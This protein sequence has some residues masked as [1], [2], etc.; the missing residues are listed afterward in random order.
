M[1][2]PSEAILSMER[3]AT[4]ATMPTRIQEL[5]R[6]LSSMLPQVDRVFVYLD[7]F[8]SVPEFLTDDPKISVF[9]AEELGNYHA[10]S[11]FL[12]LS[13][14]KIPCVLFLFDDDILYPPDY[15]ATL[16]SVLANAGGRAMVGVHGR[17]FRPPH[18]SYVRDA[19]FLHFSTGL[20]ANVQVHELGVGTCA[21]VSDQLDL[22][23]TQWPSND[24]DD[25]LLAIEAQKRAIQRIAVKRQAN[26]LQPIAENQPDS[27]WNKTRNDDLVQ[28]NLMRLLLKLY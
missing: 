18:H 14:L 5:E 13:H 17:I 22:D 27:L 1:A 3:V 20:P 12:A 25:I 16:I 2:Y 8:K 21:Y 15:A 28:S 7:N 11:R 10:S 24:M 4:V 19:A 9:R 6:S 23:L 26:W